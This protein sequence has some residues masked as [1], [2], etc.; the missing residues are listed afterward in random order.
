MVNWNRF[1]W[2]NISFS[3]FDIMHCQLSNLMIV[4][5]IEYKICII[6]PFANEIFMELSIIPAYFF[7]LTL[8]SEKSVDLWL[9]KKV[10]N[11]KDS[12]DKRYICNILQARE[13]SV[14]F[15]SVTHFT[16]LKILLTCFIS[17][18]KY[19]FFLQWPNKEIPFPCHQ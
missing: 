5:L 1:I 10:V 18:C 2:N 9:F 15:R 13:M 14:S 4:L 19:N 11:N 7:S 12:E 16:L 3:I 17:L 8:S 6:F